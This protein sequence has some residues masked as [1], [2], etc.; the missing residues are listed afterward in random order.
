MNGKP[1]QP[2][3][4]VDRRKPRNFIDEQ[5]D[6]QLAR[7][8]L[9]ASPACSDAEF[10][11]R[12]YIDTIGRLPTIDEARAFLRRS[13]ANPARCPDRQPARPAGVQRLLDLQVVRPA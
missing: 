3:A 9:P 12:A 1:A 13:V 10:V 11:R 8:N 2:G 7:L 4:I 6:K 5:I